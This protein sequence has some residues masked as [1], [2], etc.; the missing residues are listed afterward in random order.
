MRILR[1]V[2]CLVGLTVVFPHQALADLDAVRACRGVV[3]AAD[4]LACFDAAAAAL[5]PPQ[6]IPPVAP[7]PPAK[8]LPESPP[9]PRFGLRPQ[10]PVAEATHIEG[11]IRSAR[12]TAEGWLITLADGSVWRQADARAAAVDPR[13]GQTVKIERAALGAFRLMLTPNLGLKVQRVR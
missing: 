12:M 11:V 4:R 2:G 8:A 9:D 1:W 5:D 6:S 7:S 10:R 13:E 3:A